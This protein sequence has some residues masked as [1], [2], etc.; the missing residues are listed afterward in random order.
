M[1]YQIRVTGTVD[2]TRQ[3][4]REDDLNM[5]E[6]CTTREQLIGQ[7]IEDAEEQ[8]CVSTTINEADVDAIWLALKEWKAKR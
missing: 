7:L 8:M 1:T 4:V 5:Y 6:D 3:D 2:Y